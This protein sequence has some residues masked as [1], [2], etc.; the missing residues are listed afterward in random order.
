MHIKR[1]VAA[2]LS[3]FLAS[4]AFDIWLNAVVLRAEFESAADYWRPASELNRLV[5]LGW[6]SMLFMMT[7]SGMLYVRMHRHGLGQGL[8]FGSWLAV[9]AVF[10]V[11]G[12]ATLVPWPLP[13]LGGMAIQQAANSLFLG[14][15]LGLIYP[16]RS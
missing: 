9:A 6:L 5:P 2:V 11:A 8:A 15:G 12:I 1:F 10:G 16:A 4:T 7:A 13:L 14:I 3:A